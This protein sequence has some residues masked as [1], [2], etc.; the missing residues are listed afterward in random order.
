MS[1]PAD[2]AFLHVTVYDDH[3]A[4]VEQLARE[5]DVSLSE[6]LRIAFDAYRA[7]PQTAPAA[8]RRTLRSLSA[9]VYRDDAELVER[10]AQELGVNKSAATRHILEFHRSHR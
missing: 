9:Y 4:Y 2:A 5:R 1:A 8:R 3:L 10:T 6:A 7:R